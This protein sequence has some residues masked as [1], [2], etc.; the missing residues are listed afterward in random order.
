MVCYKLIILL[1][2]KKP[3]DVSFNRKKGYSMHLVRIIIAPSYQD[4]HQV[5]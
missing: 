1:D 2:H 3:V 5:F 4:V